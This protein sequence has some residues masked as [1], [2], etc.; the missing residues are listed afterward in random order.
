MTC[1]IPTLE[2]CRKIWGEVES[3]IEYLFEAAGKKKVP[4]WQD[5]SL[6]R[7]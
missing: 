2:L 7:A 1:F 4:L 6:H 5:L 3:H